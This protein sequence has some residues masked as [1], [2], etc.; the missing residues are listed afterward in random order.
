MVWGQNSLG[1][2]Q[3]FP[4]RETTL[5]RVQSLYF[6]QRWREIWVL[7]FWLGGVEIIYLLDNNVFFFAFSRLLLVFA[8]YKTYKR[9]IFVPSVLFLFLAYYQHY[10]HITFP[11]HFSLIWL[12]NLLIL[13]DFSDSRGGCARPVIASDYLILNFTSRH[14]W[15]KRRAQVFMCSPSDVHIP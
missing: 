10:I 11:T 14:Q 5:R 4:G 13:F 2:V 12:T 6:I 9:Y 15:Y 8:R 7:H 1:D 3:R